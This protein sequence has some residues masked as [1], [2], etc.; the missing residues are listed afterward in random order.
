MEPLWIILAAVAAAGGTFVFTRGQ[1]SKPLNTAELDKQLKERIE[2]IKKE[3]QDQLDEYKQELVSRIKEKEKDLEDTLEQRA[4]LKIEEQKLKLREDI[5]K[6]EEKIRS[7]SL[8]LQLELNKKQEEITKKLEEIN[9]QKAGLEEEKSGLLDRQSRVEE[10]EK[11]LDKEYKE[12]LE[13]A[14]K[15]KQSD[16]QSLIMERAEEAVGQDL[17]SYQKKA[18][19]SVKERVDEEAR[20]LVLEAV[21]RCT[22]EVANEATITVVKLKNPEDKGKIIG[23]QGR[24]IQWLEKTLGVEIVIDDTPDAVTVS[25]FNSIRRHVAKRTLEMLLEDGRVHPGAIEDMYEKAKN[26]IST[27]ITQAGH[28][29]VESLGIIDFPEKLIRIIGRLKF[30][31]SYGQNILKHSVEMARLAKLLATEMNEKFFTLPKQVD[32]DICIKG[33]LLHDIGKALDEEGATKG[34]HVLLG[35][36]VAETFNLDWRIVKCIT[37]HHDESYEDK[38]NGLCL[39]AI[40]VDACDNISGA[41]PGARKES[42]E[43]FYQRVES[44]EK[45]ASETPGVKQAWVMKGSR[46]L[47][48]FFD[49]NNIT[50]K[51]MHDLTRTIADRIQGEVRYPGEIKVLGLWE[52]RV[53]EYAN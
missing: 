25:G 10:K 51:Q 50:P 27:E 41:R 30:R 37:A 29:A 8:E 24:N 52:D 35:Q 20:Q 19:E 40:I 39:E 53:I 16:A 22:S 23:K 46:E 9:I 1:A 31:T 14:S 2:E 47:W 3:K 42:V 36:K 48:V 7:K 34:D 49:T 12:K 17:L 32:V 15:L 38:K 13:K 44:M 18:L 4:K 33:A 28:E 5:A 45:I 6:E 43:A 26:N 21:Q 11:T